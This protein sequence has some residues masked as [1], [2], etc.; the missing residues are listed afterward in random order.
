MQVNEQAIQASRQRPNATAAAPAAI[1]PEDTA[2]RELAPAGVRWVMPCSR[3]SAIAVV[4]K[5][6][7]IPEI[8]LVPDA[9]N[10]GRRAMMEDTDLGATPTAGLCV[11][12]PVHVGHARW[13]QRASGHVRLPTDEFVALT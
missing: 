6:I 1:A 10:A 8:A 11:G 2:P 3:S 4:G 9:G 13:A 5:A 7:G 12:A